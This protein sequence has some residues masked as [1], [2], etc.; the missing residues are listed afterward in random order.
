MGQ[1]E[2][3]LIYCDFYVKVIHVMG[4]IKLNSVFAHLQIYTEECVYV[5]ENYNPKFFQKKFLVC[6]LPNGSGVM[7]KRIILKF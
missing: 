3:H 6:F 4:K 1:W 7:Y 2:H 5:L